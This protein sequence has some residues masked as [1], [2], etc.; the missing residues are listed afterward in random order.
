[1]N[2]YPDLEQYE[3]T[4][5]GATRTVFKGGAGPAVIVM[6]EVP[7]LYP[8]VVEFARRVIAAGFTVYLPS[9]L[10]TPGKPMGVADNLSSI[11][12]ACVAREFSTWATGKTSPIVSWLRALAGDAHAECGGPGVGAVGMCLTGG[13]ALAMMVDDVVVAPV[14]SQPS[15]PFPISRRHRRDLGI[16]DAT[17][18]RVKQRAAQGACVMGLRFTG[19]PMV[20]AARFARLRDELGDNF[21]AVEI[22]SSIGNPHG[23]PRTAHSVLTLHFVDEPGH[24][25]RVATDRVLEFF[26]DRLN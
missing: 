24:P 3:A 4:Y 19:D 6:H 15:L 13:F 9:L 20:P 23:I 12:R 8:A 10:G 14:L 25:T 22:D 17:L 21:L 16:D 11:A 5:D 7:G 1:V 26:R 2:P 18:A